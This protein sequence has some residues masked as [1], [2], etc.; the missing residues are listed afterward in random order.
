MFGG[1]FMDINLIEHNANCGPVDIDHYQREQLACSLREIILNT[2]AYSHYAEMLD[3]LSPANSIEYLR[4]LPTLT[5]QEVLE[6][7]ENYHRIDLTER[8]YAVR[9]GG[10]SGEILSFSRIKSEYEIERLHV[11]YCWSTAGINLAQDKGV[12]LT[13]RVSKNSQDGVTYVDKNQIMWI[14]CPERTSEQWMKVYQSFNRYGPKYIRGYGSLVGGF[15]QFIDEND[16]EIPKSLEAVY[17]SSDPMSDSEKE[18]IKSKYCANLLSLY[19]QTERV[20]MGITCGQGDRF[21]LL[22]SY[23]IT[24]IVRDDGSLIESPN[25]VGYVVSTSLYP[26]SCSLVRYHTGDMGSWAEGRCECGREGPAISHFLQRRHEIITN[27]FGESV[28]IGRRNSF[29]DFRDSLPI[30]TSVQF[31]QREHGH[32]HVFIQ[33]KKKDFDLFEPAFRHL[34][35]EFNT[36]FEFVDAPILNKNGKRTLFVK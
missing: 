18:L 21:H 13:A 29:L 35:K 24:E 11:E 33:T 27:K 32:I 20:V 5:K 15:F 16:L 25:E 1:L 23:G 30:G 26:R 22:P 9:T 31:R 4:K 34:Q 19:G 3:G 8:Q 36:S 2:P 17:Y 7:P 28:N 6:N 10:T 14:G 12:V